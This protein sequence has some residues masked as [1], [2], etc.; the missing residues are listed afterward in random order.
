MTFELILILVF[1][2]LGFVV[3]YLLIL[4][5]LRSTQ[6]T[7]KTNEELESVVNKIFGMSIT[8]ITEQSKQALASEKELIKE[9]LETRQ[10]SIENLVKQLQEDLGKRQDEIR[11]LE[12]DRT[13]K[14][15]EITTAIDEHRKLTEELKVTTYQLAKVLS[16]N[17]QRG[18]WGERIIEDLLRS[19]GLV[20]GVHYARQQTLA[21]STLKPD[22]S[23]LLPN[24]RIVPV[25]VKFPY[26]EIQKMAETDVKSDQQAHMKQFAIDL[27]IKV[28]KVAEYINPSHNTLD[29]AIMFVPNEMVFS[30]INQKFPDIIDEAISKRVLIVSPFT[31]LIVARTVME[32]YRNFMIG[33]QL[34]E[35]VKYVDEFVSEWGKF[36]SQFDK[37]GRALGTLQTAYQ[38]LTVT[39]VRQMERRIESIRGVQQGSLLA[40]ADIVE[41]ADDLEDSKDEKTIN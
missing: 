30:F 39:R 13:Q 15:S 11:E 6:R 36:R 25:D 23:L 24:N 9:N 40:A 27:K 10:Q 33:D 17:Q 32:S 37:Y 8:K 3:L 5:Q 19:N 34:R 22:I 35:V 16:N 12:K 1:I 4:Q 21:N 31:F 20:E 7:V 18:G 38:D 28:K 29:Y 26:S 2:T 41:K 14:F